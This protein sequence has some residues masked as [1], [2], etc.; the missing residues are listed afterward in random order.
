MIPRMLRS[1]SAVNA[2]S[3]LRGGIQVSKEW[4]TLDRQFSAGLR[5]TGWLVP[6]NQAWCAVERT[7]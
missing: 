6:R 5:S 2:G 7:L 4:L 1:G 3:H